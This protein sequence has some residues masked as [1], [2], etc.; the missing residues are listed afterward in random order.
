MFTPITVNHNGEQYE[1]DKFHS[2][3]TGNEYF[4]VST[5]S[6]FRWIV[7]TG[8]DAEEIVAIADK[9]DKQACYYV[10]TDVENGWIEKI[11]C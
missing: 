6:N 10:T 8:R 7:V 4:Q 11:Y 9:E 1:V 3:A 2:Y 5:K